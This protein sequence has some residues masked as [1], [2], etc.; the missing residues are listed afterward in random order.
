MYR[1]SGR[2]TD[3]AAG[4]PVT[5]KPDIR[6]NMKLK[7]YTYFMWP[8]ATLCDLLWFLVT[9]TSCDPPETLANLIL[10]RVISCDLSPPHVTVGVLVGPQQTF[11]DISRPLLILAD[12]LWP[13]L[14]SFDL[15]WP[16]VTSLDLLWPFQSSWDLS[17][18]SVTS[19]V[20]LR[21]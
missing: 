6:P 2:I 20:L 1:I 15:S 5:E 8:K 9:S 16:H 18:P 12:L 10:P 14:N 13:Q 17:S 19:A 7:N 11:C 3:T 21:P 4:Y